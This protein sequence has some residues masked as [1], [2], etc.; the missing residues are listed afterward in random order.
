MA[1][2]FLV[3]IV[4]VMAELLTRNKFQWNVHQDK[5]IFIQENAFEKF[6][7]RMVAFF[8]GFKV[9]L[10]PPCSIPC[11]PP[12]QEPL[13]LRLLHSLSSVVIGQSVGYEALPLWLADIN[14][15]WDTPQL[16]WILGF[17][18]GVMRWE[19]TTYF[20]S[21]R[22]SP[23]TALTA[24]KLPAGR[25]VQGDFE[26][27]YLIPAIQATWRSQINLLLSTWWGNLK[28]SSQPSSLESKAGVEVT[29]VSW[30]SII[31]SPMPQDFIRFVGHFK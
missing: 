11:W 9:L 17:C 6:E 23:C 14:A 1:P 26:I 27:V 19:F 24:G 29:L 2:W 8:L 10:C 30:Y 5:E 20:K 18:N 22:Q 4:Q 12:R 31:N 28:T 15:D 3:K 25:S 13:I 7:C 16:H 21:H